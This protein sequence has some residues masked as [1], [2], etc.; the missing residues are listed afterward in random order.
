[1]EAYS[2]LLS[3]SID[4]TTVNICSGRAVY[5]ADILKIMNDISGHSIK[6]VIDPLLFRPDEPRTIR[7]LTIT[8]RGFDRALAQSRNP[9]N[10]DANVRCIP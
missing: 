7:T 2:R 9:R 3:Q 6:P 10:A 5:L 8:K 4:P 1:M